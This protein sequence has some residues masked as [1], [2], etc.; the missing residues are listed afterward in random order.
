MQCLPCFG[1]GCAGRVETMVEAH[2]TCINGALSGNWWEL[3]LSIEMYEGLILLGLG[4]EH[5]M[6]IF[7]N[8]AA[9]A[10]FG[11]DTVAIGYCQLGL[12]AG[13]PVM[14][15][16]IILG[17]LLWGK[18]VHLMGYLLGIH[19]CIRNSAANFHCRY[20]LVPILRGC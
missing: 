6:G 2:V 16:T 13:K 14:P 12:D 1:A 4:E 8:P 9:L 5:N 17:Y 10:I 19:P 18:G 11:V 7:L 15:F 3:Q 20:S